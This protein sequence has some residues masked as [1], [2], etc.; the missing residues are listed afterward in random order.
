MNNLKALRRRNAE[1][2]RVEGII[3]QCLEV[4]VV[5]ARSMESTNK[6]KILRRAESSETDL[7]R[8]LNESS[9]TELLYDVNLRENIFTK[10]HEELHQAKPFTVTVK[11][12][13]ALFLLHFHSFA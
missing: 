5:K 13:E 9:S 3:S 4:E 7:K 11:S 8:K 12:P 10:R 6:S 1:G 2:R